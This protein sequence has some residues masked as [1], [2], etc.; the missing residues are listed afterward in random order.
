[1]PKELNFIPRFDASQQENNVGVMPHLNG[2]ADTGDKVGSSIHHS[3]INGSNGSNGQELHFSELLEK[4]I[5][6][7]VRKVKGGRPKNLYSLLI[8][9]FERPLF[10][11]V[12]Q[13]MDGNQIRAAELL[14]V[15]RNTL[16]KK[17]TEL[18]IKVKKPGA[19]KKVVDIK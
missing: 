9:E 7:F 4:K 2:Y 12:L 10:S 6:D 17:M 18:Q 3:V 11:L 8:S 1:M 15:H 19:K 13:E 5:L 16:R 14:G